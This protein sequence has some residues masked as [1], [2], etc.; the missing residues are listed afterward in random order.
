[1][2][3][4]LLKTLLVNV[5]VPLIK[6]LIFM[7]INFFKVRQIRKEREEKDKVKVEEYEKAPSDDSFS[8]LP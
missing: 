1:M 6:D 5:V 3:A 2:W 8:N 4:N 7:A